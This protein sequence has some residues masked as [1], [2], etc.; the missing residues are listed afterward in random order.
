M[1]AN[2]LG[3]VRSYRRSHAQSPLGRVLS[4]SFRTARGNG[5]FEALAHQLTR[6]SL[7]RVES[8][9]TTLDLRR[10]VAAHLLAHIECH[11]PEL[12]AAAVRDLPPP[13][14]GAR[15]PPSQPVMAAAWVH[16][17]RDVSTS[18]QYGLEAL[19]AVAELH[20]V[21][22]CVVSA[23]HP[24]T[25]VNPSTPTATRTLT[26]FVEGTLALPRRAQGGGEEGGPARP[27]ED[28]DP[29]RPLAP[30]PP[31]RRVPTLPGA[32]LRLA[33]WNVRALSAG[34]VHE[35]AR[36]LDDH[37]ITITALQEVR[38]PGSG[39]FEV[40]GAPYTMFYHGHPSRHERGTAFMVHVGV[41]GAI[42]DHIRPPAS[43]R[44]S[45]LDI[46]AAP[47]DLSIISTYAP[48]NDAEEEQ[49]DTFYTDLNALRASV[50]AGS[51]PI[52]LGDFKAKI[53]REAEVAD[54]A[55][56]HSLHRVN[57]ENGQRLVD[58]AAARDMVV[59]S[60]MNPRSAAKIITW[61]S[62][63][64][65][66]RNQIDHVL[67]PRRLGAAFTTTTSVPEANI[68]SDH[69]MVLAVC[70]ISPTKRW[71]PRAPPSKTDRPFAV[72]GLKN[73]EKAK[74]Y[75]DRL[76][77]LLGTLPAVE[78]PTP[79]QLWDGLRSAIITAAEEVLGRDGA[80]RS[81]HWFDESCE[82]AILKTAAAHDTLMEAVEE[83][84]PE[85]I[86]QD[87]VGDW[88]DMQREARSVCQRTKR[89]AEHAK[90]DDM[91][92]CF[93]VKDSAAFFKLARSLR[94]RSGSSVGVIK[95]ADGSLLSDPADVLARW[96]DWFKDLLNGPP[97]TSNTRP[98]SSQQR[99]GK[100]APPSID[101]IQDIIG[102]LKKRSAPGVDGIPAPLLQHGGR[103]VACALKLIIDTI[104][105]EGAMPSEWRR[106]LPMPLPKKGDL[107]QC[108]NYRGIALLCVAYK[109]FAYYIFR[110]LSPYASRLVGDYQCRFRPRRSTT[111]QIVLL[112]AILEHRWEA[113]KDTYLL[114]VDFA[115]AYDCVHRPSLYNYLAGAGV[116]QR[117]VDIIRVSQE[118][119]SCAVRF[120][121]SVSDF[122]DVVSGVKQGDP[123]APMHFNLALEGA[124]GELH[125]PLE[126]PEHLQHPA[127]LA[128]ADDLA[129][130]AD[131]RQ[132][133]VEV[134]T[135]VRD[136]ALRFGLRISP[137]T[138]FMVVSRRTED[139]AHGD[140]L[141]V[142]LD[143]FER[144]ET[145]KYLGVLIDHKNS[146]DPEIRARCLG[147]LRT[148]HSLAPHLRS[149]KVSVRAKVR[150]FEAIERPAILYGA[151][152]WT[153]NK[154]REARIAVAENRALRRAVGPIYDEE[155]DRY[156]WRSNAECRRLTEV[157]DWR[158]AVQTRDAWRTFTLG[159]EE[160][161]DPYE[162]ARQA[163]KRRKAERD[164]AR[165]A[166]RQLDLGDPV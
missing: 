51:L 62:N 144:V 11:Q 88:I 101:E 12:V 4:F 134:C 58:L 9:L 40:R 159:I 30:A 95:G 127:L 19:R 67:V 117:L 90:L 54:L 13:P 32:P 96:R 41:L 113:G 98:R 93:K 99:R 109:V 14:C 147:G 121:G 25:L 102:E 135:R 108:T 17:L 83:E 50:P 141:Q 81:A 150:L 48:V 31:P 78:H 160:Q 105:K 21:A 6:C 64:G 24:P 166:A 116:S 22:I 53:G 35:L 82:E 79:D 130:V 73:P 118:A 70:S 106:S 68:G 156:V 28:L 120:R 163:A 72:G 131:T 39:I 80:T 77:E 158:E 165:D 110:R 63:D 89:A 7:R 161:P 26:I 124:L 145:F 149:K 36:Q 126:R 146:L 119:S 123:L 3:T 59:R 151:E 162:A 136:N 154:E 92:S 76:A 128:Y 16:R 85:D 103:E 74:A 18:G 75:H 155:A 34:A 42:K 125:V 44:L 115:K 138:N 87:L 140:A 37:Q 8:P 122:F 49:K 107:S 61:I 157:A 29:A 148:F 114:F 100:V 139:P 47:H 43:D 132:A 69:L 142:G 71:A 129:V 10:A 153:L 45:R 5:L 20:H 137:K 1:Q 94:Q 84:Y 91:E 104:I 66:T 57:N 56:R 55:G 38:W 52:L 133:L 33:S 23:V 143:S 15:P 2:L 27:P 152:A 60:T 97:G 65:V 86:I 46:H 111:D 164:A 112:R